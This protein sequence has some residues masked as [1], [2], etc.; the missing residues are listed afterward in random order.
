M[1]YTG[2]IVVTAAIL[3]ALSFE[4]L[5]HLLMEGRLYS[6]ISLLA[7]VPFAYLGWWLGEQYDAA[8][9]AAV[10]DS[11]TNLYNRRQIYVQFPKLAAKALRKKAKLDCWVIDVNDFKSINDTSGHQAGDVVLVHIARAL[12]RMAG[13]HDLVARWGG[14]EFVL[15][16]PFS[17]KSSRASVARL[18]DLM[19]ELSIKLKKNITVTVGRAVFPDDASTI[20]ELIRAA[21]RNLYCSKMERKPER[22]SKG[23]S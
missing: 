6:T 23:I 4:M 8:Q 13:P 20:D 16:S 15:I 11:L 9:Y 19:I 3:F 21:D 5:V 14:D 1:K 22:S 2:R 17:D 12:Q 7:F 10:R 18:D